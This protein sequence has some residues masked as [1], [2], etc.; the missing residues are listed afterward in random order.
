MCVFLSSIT[1]NER[2]NASDPDD[3]HAQYL[4]PAFAL[5]GTVP[6]ASALA[7]EHMS[8]AE[9]EA[10]LAEMAPDIRAADRDMT[11]IEVLERKGVTGAGTLAGMPHF[12]YRS[13][14]MPP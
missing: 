4:T 14:S 8:A 10:L 11:E 6:S 7:N 3:Q 12:L 1:R 13:V 9:L 2:I 5:S